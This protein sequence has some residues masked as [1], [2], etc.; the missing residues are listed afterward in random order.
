MPLE[1]YKESCLKDS[2]VLLMFHTTHTNSSHNFIVATTPYQCLVCN[3][4]VL[5]KKKKKRIRYVLPALL[6]DNAPLLPENC[7]N[8][9]CFGIHMFIY[10]VCIGKTQKSEEKKPNLLSFH[11]ELQKWTGQNYWH[12]F[13]IVRNNCISSM[14]C[15]FNLYLNSPVA[16]N[17]CW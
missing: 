17:R 12:L 16:S 6:S 1:Y 15:S 10:F 13:K 4:F 11:T 2:K 8:Y 7:C 5:R 14:W 9:K 3:A